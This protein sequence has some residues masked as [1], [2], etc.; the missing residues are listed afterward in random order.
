MNG[1]RWE[2]FDLYAPKGQTPKFAAEFG[3]S[4]HEYYLGTEEGKDLW[5]FCEAGMAGI[6]IVHSE[7]PGDYSTVYA[8]ALV[9]DIINGTGHYGH[10]E[11]TLL[12][13]ALKHGLV[14][15]AVN[16]TI[17]LGVEEK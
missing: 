14:E 10:V 12:Q 4:K 6:G 5:A 2:A 7:E 17:M 3:Y 15:V 1:K 11:R 16:P 9:R 13:R 8:P